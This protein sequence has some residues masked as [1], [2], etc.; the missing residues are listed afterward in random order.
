MLIKRSLAVFAALFI[1]VTLLGMGKGPGTEV[2]LPEINFKATVRDDQDITTKVQ[3]A[4][5]EG[6]IFF[7]GT[8]GKGTVT[9]FFEKI[10]KITATGTGAEN[11]S[12]FQVTMKNGDV[13][14]ISLDN[15]QRFFGTTNYGTYRVL[16]K[17]IKEITFE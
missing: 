14:A 2:P 6:E 8:R 15:D 11:K 17:N 3:N 5:W 13:V 7:I 4:S 12:D 10:R 9:V 16:A 1:W